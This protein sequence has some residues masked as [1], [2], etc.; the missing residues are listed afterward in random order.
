MLAQAI[1][2]TRSRSLEAQICEQLRLASSSTTAQQWLVL[3]NP[4]RKPKAQ[5]LQALGVNPDQILMVH[6]RNRRQFVLALK[7]ALENGTISGVMAWRGGLQLSEVELA[8]VQDLA[9]ST[10]KNCQL[11]PPQQPMRGLGAT[12]ST[13]D[14][15]GHLLENR[16]S[17]DWLEQELMKIR[18]QLAS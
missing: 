13:F 2:P 8:Q 12:E 1:K 9:I 3:I 4:P 14:T 16:S 7:Q 10:G 6:P 17:N 18:A 11:I 15:L 5:Q